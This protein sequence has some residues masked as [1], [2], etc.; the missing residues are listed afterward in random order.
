MLHRRRV[1]AV[2]VLVAAALA[3]AAAASG[4]SGARA[5][6]AER[7][8]SVLRNPFAL[9]ASR[10]GDL[11]LS[12][13][14]QAGLYERLADGRIDHLDDLSGVMTMLTGRSGVI[15]AFGPYSSSG[16][17]VRTIAPDGRV[18]MIVGPC[19]QSQ[20]LAT[21][22]EA[23]TSGAIAPDGGLYLNDASFCGSGKGGPVLELTAAG[24]VVTP[25]FDAALI[26]QGCRPPR[27][28][29]VSAAVVYVACDSSRVGGKR[30]LAL[31]QGGRI[32]RTFGAYPYSSLNG[33]APLPGGGVVASD[34]FKIV[35]LTPKGMTTLANFGYG[36]ADAS[37]LG[38]GFKHPST[39]ADGLAVDGAGNVYFSATSAIA[40]GTFTGIVEIAHDGRVSVLW[41]GNPR[42][43]T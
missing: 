17:T 7:Q 15:Y 20:A 40:N 42:S 3:C 24:K 11:Y 4:A 41:R 27:A 32:L 29:A 8:A 12:G 10:N 19:G 31:S 6:G 22:V 21:G 2:T 38:E 5:E 18:T 39:E 1:F 33:I 16:A 25:P 30:M 13:F 28:L 43:Q 34:Y 9:T 26:R 36:A 23:G 14:E 37:L 35:K